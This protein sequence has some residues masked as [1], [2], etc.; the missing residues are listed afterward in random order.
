M[1]RLLTILAW[2]I[3]VSA[4]ADSSGVTAHLD[5]VSTNGTHT[6]L[7]FTCNV[8]LDNQTGATLTATAFPF[9]GLVLR[10]TDA[11][12][13]SLAKIHP[14]PMIFWSFYS[15]K[16]KFQLPPGSQTFSKLWYAQD[17]GSGSPG[18]SLPSDVKRVRLQIDGTLSGTSYT[19]R[20]TS[21][22]VEVQVP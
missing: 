3:S 18:L 21:N 15:E 2:L 14:W 9:T 20:V 10:V 7:M 6:N 4:F 1:K 19:N 13:H 11:D 12:G 16:E 8:T 5:V 22:T 17:N